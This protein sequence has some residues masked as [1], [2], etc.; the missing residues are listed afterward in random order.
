MHG[1][2][3][4]GR[5][6]EARQILR[7]ADPDN[8]HDNRFSRWMLRFL[9]AELARRG[10]QIWTDAEMES[11]SVAHTRLAHPYGFYFQATARQR[12]RTREDACHRFQRAQQFFLADMGRDDE[13]NIAFFL[14]EAMA[15]AQAGW[16]QN[17]AE[18]Q[19]ALERLRRFA[20]HRSS[21]G[22]KA[23][24]RSVWP[25]APSG[26]SREEAERLLQHIPFF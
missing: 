18:W 7:R 13:R 4:H 12:G 26:P 3:R 25:S 24:Y 21:R 23:H 16:Q 11:Q 17:A 5:L 6:R 19:H 9:Q 8:L 14:A 15:L 22:L 20:Q 2:L 1:Y 10:G